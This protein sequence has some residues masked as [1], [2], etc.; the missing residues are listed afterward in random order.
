ML[1][2]MSWPGYKCGHIVGANL[3]ALLAD[4]NA[5]VTIGNVLAFVN[6]CDRDGASSRIDRCEANLTFVEGTTCKRYGP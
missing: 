6:L 2:R 3:D 5:I 4:R 1:G